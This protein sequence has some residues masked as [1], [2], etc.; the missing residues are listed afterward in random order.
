MSILSPYLGIYLASLTKYHCATSSKMTS[1]V[2]LYQAG[3]GIYEQFDKVLLI[4]KGQQIYFGPA[5]RAREH[6][7]SLGWKDKPR[8][9]TAD[10][11]TGCTDENERCVHFYSR[12]TRLRYDG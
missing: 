8:Q 12:A 5:N 4:D 1:F 2:S 10:F 7:L 3:E 11:L 6:M 9:T